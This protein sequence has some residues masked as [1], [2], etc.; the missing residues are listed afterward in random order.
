[1]NFAQSRIPVLFS[2][3]QSEYGCHQARSYGEQRDNVTPI[4]KFSG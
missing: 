3:L 4:P 2:N 1:M